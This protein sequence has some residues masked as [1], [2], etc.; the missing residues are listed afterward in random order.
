[1]PGLDQRRLP[2]IRRLYADYLYDFGR[3]AGFYPAG[4]PQLE[5]LA[6]S[7]SEIRYP[8]AAREAM[9]AV[10]ARQNAASG[11]A[12]AANLQRFAQSDAAAILTGQQVGLF[13]GPLLVAAKAMTAVLLANRLRQRGINAVPVFWLATQDH[14][15][16]E[17]N[18]AWALDAESTPRSFSLHLADTG[19]PVGPLRLGDAV[20]QLLAE[21]ERCCQRELPALRDA[22]RPGATLGGAFGELLRKWFEPWGLLTFDPLAA[23]EIAALWAPRYQEVFNRQPELAALLAER[24]A[25]LEHAG[26]HAQVEQTASA[27]MLFLHQEGARRGLRRQNDRWLVGEAA[28][29]AEEIRGWLAQRPLEVSPAAL[30]RPLLQDIAFPTLAQVTGPAETA[31]L[32]QS[33][34]LYRA[35]GVRQPVAWPRASFTLLDP[36]AQRLLARY[37]VTLEELFAQPAADLLARRALPEDVAAKAAA[38]RENF[39]REYAALEAGLQRL[40]PTLADAGNGAAQKIRHQLEQLE[41]RVARSF[42]RRSTEIESQARHLEGSLFPR[43]TLQE[44]L[45]AAAPWFAQYP[46][47]PAQLH[48]ALDPA[49][50]DHQILAL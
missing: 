27:A 7:A 15:L 32:A 46:E 20:T 23:P 3:V 22:Y 19:G 38:L 16:A 43:R 36:K 25:A 39:E 6:A 21:L 14:D 9:A 35:L 10:L 17:V 42:A 2:G 5:R 26:Y 34:V 29:G 12:A 41:A 1:M 8:A 11:A 45:L 44:R 50:P 37:Q 28:A 33:A 4:P 30:L 48:A 47:L 13:G 24:N 31:Y 18:Q 49:L 40:D